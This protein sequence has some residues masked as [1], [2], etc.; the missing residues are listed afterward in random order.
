MPFSNRFRVQPQVKELIRECFVQFRC[1]LVQEKIID[2]EAIFIDGTK[3]EAYANKFSFVWKKSI[4]RYHAKFIEK[5]NAI[6][7]ELLQNE[8]IP[9]IQRESEE[10]LSIPELA[11]V[12]QAVDEVV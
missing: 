5:S 3:I 7:N 11:Q 1:Q 10:Q 2:H 4:E 9:E 12:I 6:Y 8:I